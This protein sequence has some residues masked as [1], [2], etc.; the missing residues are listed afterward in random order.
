VTVCA[1]SETATLDEGARKGRKRRL[2][3]A[4]PA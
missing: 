1:R 4:L 2:R 3:S